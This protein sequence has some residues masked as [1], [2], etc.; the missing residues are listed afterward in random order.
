[1][2]ISTMT[3]YFGK[4]YAEMMVKVLV[5]TASDF[6]K[7]YESDKPGMPDLSD[8]SNKM[9]QFM[10]AAP[11]EECENTMLISIGIVNA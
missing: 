2:K 4:M 5:V 7:T 11:M 10:T 9:I 3:K 1:M 8:I 6:S